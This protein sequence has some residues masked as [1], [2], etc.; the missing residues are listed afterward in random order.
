[1]RSFAVRV[2]DRL[3]NRCWS[4]VRGSVAQPS[5]ELGSPAVGIP[6]GGQGT[7]VPV[8]A[9]DLRHRRQK[10][11]ALGGDDGGGQRSLGAEV[12]PCLAVPYLAGVVATPAVDPVS[13]IEQPGGDAGVGPPGTDVERG[14]DVVV[15]VRAHL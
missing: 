5:I 15:E 14:V 1:Q 7:G 4:R 12:A 3:G 9:V 11:L 10:S 2:Q 8:T 13:G 6:I